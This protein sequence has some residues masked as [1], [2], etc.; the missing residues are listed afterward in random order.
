MSFPVCVSIV[1]GLQRKGKQTYRPLRYG[2][3]IPL[4]PNGDHHLNSPYHTTRI[5]VVYQI[6]NSSGHEKTGNDHQGSVKLT[7]INLY[8]FSLHVT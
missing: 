4:H 5:P 6:V 3:L 2:V 7:Y 1:T 8:K